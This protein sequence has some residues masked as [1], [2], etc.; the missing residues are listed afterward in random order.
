MILIMMEIVRAFLIVVGRIRQLAMR[1]GSITDGRKLDRQ[2]PLSMV[3][4]R[5][6]GEGGSGE[7]DE[8][9]LEVRPMLVKFNISIVGPN[10]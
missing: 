1:H 2:L 9:M 10:G 6:I 5:V 8:A 7:L 4:I 3:Q